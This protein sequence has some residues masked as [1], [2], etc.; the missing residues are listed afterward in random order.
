MDGSEKG[1]I[2]VSQIGNK[3]VSRRVGDHKLQGS[4]GGGQLRGDAA[5]PKQ[6]YFPVSNGHGVAELRAIQ[7]LDPDGFR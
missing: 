2:F 7:I 4:R 3:H 5:G 1:Q 6:G